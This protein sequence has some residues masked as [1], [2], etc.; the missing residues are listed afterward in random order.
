MKHVRELLLL[1]R[2]MKT[3]IKII[4]LG[5][6]NVVRMSHLLHSTGH[7]HLRAANEM[8]GERWWHT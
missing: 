5:D 1:L 3:T 4:I 8:V 6:R 7:I 2:L